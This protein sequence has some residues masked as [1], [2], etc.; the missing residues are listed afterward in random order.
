MK[1]IKRFILVASCFKKFLIRRFVKPADNWLDKCEPFSRVFGLDRGAAIDRYFIEDFLKSNRELVQGS[2]LEV[3]DDRYICQFGNNVNNA[4]VIAGQGTDGLTS[5]YDADLTLPPSFEKLGQ[6]DCVIATNVLNF[7]V[8][9]EKAI[10]GLS[11]LV[12]EN[13]VC[14][15]TAAGLVSIS[16]YDYDRWGDYWR[17][18]DKSL[19]LVFEKYFEN[20]EVTTYGNAPLAAAFVMGLSQ[21]EVPARLFNIC[22]ADYQILIAVKASSPKRDV[23]LT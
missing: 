13:G 18:N 1:L 12:G 8:D 4:V 11:E 2:V 22:D 3:G 6:F 23:V 14:L 9:F 17:F 5:S 19:R 16:R 21:E 20:V 10:F 15:C 7:I